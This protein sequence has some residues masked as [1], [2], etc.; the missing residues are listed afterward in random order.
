MNA[1]EY[2]HRRCPLSAYAEGQPTPGERR[3]IEPPQPCERDW[4]ALR[5]RLSDECVPKLPARRAGKWPM[6]IAGSLA[7]AIC[8]VVAVANMPKVPK[9]LEAIAPSAPFDPLAEYAVLPI[10]MPEDFQLLAVREP[11]DLTVLTCKDP[12]G[13]RM[14]LVASH[15]ISIAEAAVKD[16]LWN[17]PNRAPMVF[18]ENLDK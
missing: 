17:A 13:D 16:P 3:A 11:R 9:P 14:N 5:L 2:P 12:I 15:E 10:A 6:W 18:V 4:E 1:P 8:L 7:L